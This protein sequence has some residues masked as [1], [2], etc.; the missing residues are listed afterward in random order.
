L[1]TRP[2]ADEFDL[3]QHLRLNGF[4]REPNPPANPRL[5]SHG[6]LAEAVELQGE[7]IRAQMIE[8]GGLQALARGRTDCRLLTIMRLRTS[9]RRTI[10]RSSHPPRA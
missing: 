4:A 10:A 6:E 8:Q 2:Q 1:A 9:R 5:V 3:P 7:S